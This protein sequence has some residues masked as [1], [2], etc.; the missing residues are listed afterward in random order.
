MSSG[1][2]RQRWLVLG[3]V[4]SGFLLTA[5]CDTRWANGG[6]PIGGVTA[7]AVNRERTGDCWAQCSSG[8]ICDRER[9]VCVDAE[10]A[11]ACSAGQVCEKLSVGFA[12]VSEGKGFT[13]PPP[14]RPRT[15]GR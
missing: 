1:P 3:L 8:M 6:G 14:S 4:S 2:R 12:C 5:A 13:T 7:A 15:S 11:P 10:C 9:G